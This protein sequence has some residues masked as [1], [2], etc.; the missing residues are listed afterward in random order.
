MWFVERITWTFYCCRRKGRKVR[1][2]FWGKVEIK[3]GESIRWKWTSTG[4]TGSGRVGSQG[5]VDKQ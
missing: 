3:I 1:R 2:A 5:S 4:S